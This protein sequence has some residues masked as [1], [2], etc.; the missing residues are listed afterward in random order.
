MATTT[1]LP[2]LTINYLT[3]AQFDALSEK[4]ANE[5]YL[6]PDSSITQV[7]A[8]SGLSGGG[9]SG[10]VTINHSNSVS[11]QS[12]QAVYPIKIDGQGHISAYGT[13]VTIVNTRGTAAS[14]GTTL[15]LVNTGDMYTWNNKQDKLTNPVTGT[16]TSGYI[17][18][19]NGTGSITNGPQIGTGTT[20]FLR[21]DGS[22]EVPAYTTN[23]DENVKSTAVTAATTN[24]IVGSTTSTTTTGGL[25]KHASAVLYTTADSGTSGYTQLRLGNAT[26]TSSAGGKEGQIRLYGTN[27]T[28]YIDLKAGAVASSNKTITFPNKTGTVALTDDIPDVS[29]F[30]TTDS[31]EKL[32]IAA[33]TSGTTYYPIVAANSTAAANRQYDS[34]GIA[35]K[36][37]N[38]TANGTNGEALLTLGNSTASTTANWK[39]GKI[40]LYSSSAYGGTLVPTAIT[41]SSKTWTLPNKT[42][43]IALTDDIPSYTDTNTTYALSNALSSHKFTETLTAGGSGSGTSTATMEFAA[44]TGITLTDDTTNKKITIACSVTNSDEKV[45][46][47]SNTGS[48]AVPLVLGPTSISSGSTYNCLYNTNLKYTPSTGNLQTTQLNGVAVGSAPKFSDTVTTVTSSGSGNVVTG[49]S[50]SNGAITYTLGTVSTTAAQVIRW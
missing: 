27:A 22:W 47:T 5:I 1:S 45:K 9:S 38:G 20:K 32:K 16:G 25:S 21:E 33:V 30:I 36:G 28:Y 29:G 3:Q 26:A 34:T 41:S 2:K 14:G 18:K 39:A 46:L 49:M 43:T 4:N 40:F 24:Y 44:G 48:T 10:S 31:D 37:T 19:W 35:Y 12:T 17:A 11:T 15:S 50:A 42:G 6:T 23:T 7:S 8:G 13:A